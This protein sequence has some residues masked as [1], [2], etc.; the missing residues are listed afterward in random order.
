MQQ[1]L[2]L[3]DSILDLFVISPLSILGL[4]VLLVLALLVGKRQLEAKTA[5]QPGIML[6]VFFLGDCL[7]KYLW[8][9]KFSGIFPL[10]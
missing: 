4:L 10:A 3:L 2:S 8:Y 1:Q 5:R 7:N 9:P 6:P